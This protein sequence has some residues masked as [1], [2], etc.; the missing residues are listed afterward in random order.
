M[1]RRS[2]TALLALYFADNFTI[3]REKYSLPFFVKLGKARLQAYNK[4][5]AYG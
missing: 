5:N 2:F 1:S 4:R 3:G